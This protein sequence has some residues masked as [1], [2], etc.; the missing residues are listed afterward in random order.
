MFFICPEEIEFDR[1]YNCAIYI[2]A[3]CFKHKCKIDINPIFEYDRI[4]DIF[5]IR[6][7]I[8]RMINSSLLVLFEKL[9][10]WHLAKI[11]I[12]LNWV[13]R[14]YQNCTDF[15]NRKNWVYWTHLYFLNRF[16]IKK[17]LIIP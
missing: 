16:T 5:L 2:I 7:D 13:H 3:K 15:H 14:T 11:S 4:I 8:T 1:F 6:L 12:R 17:Q 9:L 10:D